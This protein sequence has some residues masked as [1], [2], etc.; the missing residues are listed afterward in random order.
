MP[1]KS[2]RREVFVNGLSI[3][4]VLMMAVP[5]SRAQASTTTA[6]KSQPGAESPYVATMEFDV[7]SVR[8]N[9]NLDLNTGVMVSGGFVVNTTVFH[10]L[11]LSIENLISTAYGL[12]ISQIV[13]LPKWQWP[14]V[15]VVEA[16]GGSDSDMRMAALTK[17][18]QLAEQRHML[19]VLLQD[20][21]NLKAHWET[22]EKDVY[23][24]VQAKGG[25]K[26]GS[27]GSIPISPDEVKYFNGNP[28][29]ALYQRN[30]GQGYDFFA[31]GCTMSQLARTL[32]GQFGR[33][34]NDRTGLS[35]KY[36]FVLKYKG[37]WDRDRDAEDF[38]P[39]PPMD[40]ALVEELGLK[41]ES[42]KGDVDVLVIDEVAKPSAN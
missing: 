28:V 3:L 5:S 36:D 42:A 2:L 25:T 17:E 6:E 40:R 11:N 32:T 13:N 12:D 4:T 31:H 1:K 15:F 22:K 34:V 9:K 38:D 27:A 10:G 18:R 35:G 20:R 21:F 41:V 23:N 8:E 39:L 26:L 7:A 29:P 33:P 14:T 37:R 24:L 30:D 16:K 19:Q